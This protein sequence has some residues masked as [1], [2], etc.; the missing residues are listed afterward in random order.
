[1]SQHFDGAAKESD[2]GILH[3]E[4]AE[5]SIRIPAHLSNLTL[6]TFLK[7]RSCC[8]LIFFWSVLTTLTSI[9]SLY[10]AMDVHSA[11][12]QKQDIRDKILGRELVTDKDSNFNGP[13]RP[14]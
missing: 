8:K 11:F 10:Y 13:F 12:I 2:A 14:R 3:K 4:S 6:E 1:M 7:S 9:A 5:T